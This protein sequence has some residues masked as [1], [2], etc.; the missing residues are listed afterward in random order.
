M[1]ACGVDEGMIRNSEE[2]RGSVP[3]ANTTDKRLETKN[4]IRIVGRF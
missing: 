4:T 1:R 2:W 3:V